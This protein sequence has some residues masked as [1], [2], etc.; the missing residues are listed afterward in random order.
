MVLVIFRRRSREDVG[1][2]MRVSA[3]AILSRMVLSMDV[4]DAVFWS[5]R[6]ASTELHNRSAASRATFFS[7]RWFCICCS[8]CCKSCFVRVLPPTT[9]RKRP[10]IFEL[11]DPNRP[12]GSFVADVDVCDC[13]LESA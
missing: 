3:L 10:D 8:G 1:V 2:R 6:S 5:N 9:L 7:R 12:D 13:C 11:A 4:K